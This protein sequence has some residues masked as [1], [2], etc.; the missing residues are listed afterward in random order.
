MAAIAV[1]RN[2]E[3]STTNVG[4]LDRIGSERCFGCRHTRHGKMIRQLL[5]SI[6]T[7]PT[8]VRPPQNVFGK[9]AVASH[10]LR[11]E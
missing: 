8:V 7:S 5:I 11:L 10:R 6:Q 9:G 1:A 3:I 2:E 4:N